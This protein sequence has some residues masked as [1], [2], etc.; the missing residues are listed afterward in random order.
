MANGGWVAT[1]EDI[2][3]QRRTEEERDRAEDLLREQKVQLD[4]GAQQT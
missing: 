3:E 2:T 1:F 4:H